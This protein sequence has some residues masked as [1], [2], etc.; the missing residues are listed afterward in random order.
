ME[1]VGREERVLMGRRELVG[2]S[3]LRGREEVMCG[4]EEIGRRRRVGVF[5]EGS[6][7]RRFGRASGL[8]GGRKGL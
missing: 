1:A 5:V 4:R 7:G 8:G 2:K 6:G 3:V